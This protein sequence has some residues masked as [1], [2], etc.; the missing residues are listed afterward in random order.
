MTHE[1][2]NQNPQHTGAWVLFTQASF[3]ASLALVAVG[4]LFMPID[5]WMKGY[6]GMGVVL[7]VQSCITATKTIRDVHESRRMLNRIEDAKTERL[8]MS[9]GKD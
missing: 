3:V 6:L 4:L 9:V 8:L 5:I 2:L 1:N 7:L